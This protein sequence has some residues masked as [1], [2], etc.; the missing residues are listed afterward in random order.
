ML[1]LLRKSCV[2]IVQSLGT[3]YVLYTRH[4]HSQIN[5]ALCLGI[6]PSFVLSLFSDFE[7]LVHYKFIQFNRSISWVVHTIHRPY[8]CSYVYINTINNSYEGSEAL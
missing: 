8:Y 1:N 4:L 5:R 7:Q 3:K 2:Y 6:N